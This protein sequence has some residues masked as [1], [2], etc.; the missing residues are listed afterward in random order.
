M[1][2]NISKLV[3]LVYPPTRR[4]FHRLL[5]AA[6][7]AM[8]IAASVIVWLKGQHWGWST[9]NQIEA[10]A[11]L[12][13][14]YLARAKAI[15]QSL[16]SA[17]DQLPIPESDSGPNATDP[18]APQ[19]AS[20]KTPVTVPLK[21]RGPGATA[22]LPL[23]IGV[24]AGMVCLAL[25]MRT[26]CAEDGPQAGGCFAAGK[27]C[28]GPSAAITVASFNLAT[29]QFSGGVA[30]GVGYG[31]TYAPD[32]WYAVGLDLYGSLRLGQGQPNQATF[33]LMGHFAN[34]LFVGIGPSITQRDGHSALVQWSILGGLGIPIG[35]TTSY[36]R[37]VGVR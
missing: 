23:V 8:A 6:L 35:G 24:L 9:W 26:A 19:P 22:L 25:T 10:Q 29:S 37:E 12:L 28:A 16:D 4:K 33:S 32:R 11:V 5:H 20:E 36:V 21:P 14:T 27:L 15:V 18:A 31:L 1:N 30:P 3:S 13:G 7:A 17:V 34:Y 2:A